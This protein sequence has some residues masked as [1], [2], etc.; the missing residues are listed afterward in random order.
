M[1]G[2][3]LVQAFRRKLNENRGASMLALSVLDS[4]VIPIIGDRADDMPTRLG[5]V[6]AALGDHKFRR[7]Q[8]E[9][10]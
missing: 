9:A 8:I 4:I 1:L 5:D 3:K 2:M 7:S 10:A 6:Y